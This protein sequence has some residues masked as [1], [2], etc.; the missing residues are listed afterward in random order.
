MTEAPFLQATRDAYDALSAGHLH[1][2]ATDL[3]DKP[4]DRALLQLF[5]EWVREGGNPAVLDAGCGPGRLTHALHELGLDASGLDLSPA[6]VEVAG[7]T[8]PGL[9][10]TVGSLL[11]LP[12]PDGALGGVLANYS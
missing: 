4:V 6:M 7:R 10:F 9:R 5:A 8:Y 2:V 11:D 3:T 12:V 1:V